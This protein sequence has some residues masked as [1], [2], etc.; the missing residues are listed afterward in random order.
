MLRFRATVPCIVMLITLGE[1]L[2]MVFE[3][4]SLVRT[5]PSRKKLALSLTLSVCGQVVLGV[6]VVRMNWLCVQAT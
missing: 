6:F 1:T 5:R 2:A 3:L 4:T